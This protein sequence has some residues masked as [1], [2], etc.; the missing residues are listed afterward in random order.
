M[1]MKKCSKRRVIRTAALLLALLMLFAVPGADRALL[2]DAAATGDPVRNLRVSLYWGD[3]ALLSASLHNDVG[4]GFDFGYFDG[5]RE[6]VSLTG[7]DERAITM[8]NNWTVY[9]NGVNQQYESGAKNSIVIGSWT[10]LLDTCSTAEE[11]AKQA[12]KYSNGFHAWL[13]G[14]WC[15]CIGSYSSKED[16]ERVMTGLG[17]KGTAVTG[18]DHCVVVA[19][20]ETDRVLFAFDDPDGRA[21]GVMPRVSGGQKAITWIGE[22]RYYGGFQ[23]DRIGGGNQTVVNFVGMDDYAAC[24]VPYEMREDWPIEALKAQA[25]AVR[26]YAAACL[27]KHESRGCD[28][29]TGSD[30]Q[31]YGGVKADAPRSDKAVR[32]TSGIYVT[33]NGEIALTLYYSCNGGSTE[34]NENVYTDPL[35]YLRGKQDPYEITVRTGFEDW[36]F[37]ITAGEL[38]EI[39]RGSGRSC[40][41]IVGVTPKYTANGNVYSLTF[42]DANGTDWK[43]E[44]NEARTLISG[45]GGHN[46]LSLHYTVTDAAG[47]AGNTTVTEAPEYYVNGTD[48]RLEDAS[49]VYA[50]DGTGGKQ[51]IDISGGAALRTASGVETVKA[52]VTSV[53]SAGGGGMIRAESYVFTGSGYGHNVGMSQFGAMAMAEQGFTYKDI[54]NFYYTGVKIG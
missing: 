9:W 49:A 29:C 38:T 13:N 53:P 50:L 47:S 37:P 2:P 5:N 24:V 32:D 21:L 18:S 35:P 7:T 45:Y 8:V 54:L 28:V 48:A 30:C 46:T 44:K 16:A 3:Y 36:T 23:F 40:A 52:V 41:K 43:V 34:D 17:Y 19:Q 4:S 1:Q 42:T 33:Y 20:T 15:V 39:L 22:K 11:A 27:G 26:S 31:R 25:V 14:E 6:F 10:I 51:R 12:A